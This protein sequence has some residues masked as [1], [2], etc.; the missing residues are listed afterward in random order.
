MTRQRLEK[1]ATNDA[2]KERFPRRKKKDRKKARRERT[3][4]REKR[5]FQE[6][7]IEIDKTRPL[8]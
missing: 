4:A 1:K 7:G 6:S 5:W 3:I 8:A 2:Y